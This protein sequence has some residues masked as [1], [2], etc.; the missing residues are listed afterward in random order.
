MKFKNK[1]ENHTFIN[2]ANSQYKITSKFF[3]KPRRTHNSVCYN[4]CKKKILNNLRQQP[5]VFS[6]LNSQL[7]IKNQKS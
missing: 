1:F 6:S 3:I 2:T 5:M 7:Q 4:L